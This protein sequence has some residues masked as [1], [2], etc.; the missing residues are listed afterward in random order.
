[1]NNNNEIKIIEFDRTF[2]KKWDSFVDESFNGTIFNKIKFL[3]YHSS[4]RFNFRFLGFY[5]GKNRLIGV[6]P[7]SID[8]NILKS[9]VGASYGGIALA[10]MSFTK[11]YNVVKALQIWA[12]KKNIRQIYFTHAPLIYNERL[13]QD[14]DFV[15][16]YCGFQNYYNQFSSVL[17]LAWFKEGD[18]LNNLSPAGR[19]AV[20]KSFTEGVEVEIDQDLKK[21]YPILMKNKAKFNVKPAHTLEELLKL[22]SIFP[23]KLNLFS[24]KHNGTTIGGIYT[25]ACNKRVLLAFYIA[26]LPEYQYA[27]PINRALYEVAKWALSKKYDYLDLGVSMNT[28]ADNPMEP[29]WSLISFKEHIGTRGFLRPSYRWDSSSFN[30]ES[31]K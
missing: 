18:A 9:P 16:I 31:V 5:E 26:S 17:D 30:K 20:R 2:E 1:M 19:R 29:A 3:N 6:L 28:A 21:Y 13:E 24:V 22:K 25:F 11:I 8:K 4:N 27:R 23:D 15:L 12:L 10:N 7:C 14:L